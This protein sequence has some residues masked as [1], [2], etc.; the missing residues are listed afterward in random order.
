MASGVQFQDVGSNQLLHVTANA[1]GKVRE[2]IEDEGNADL[3]LRVYVTGGGCSGFQYGFTFDEKVADD[4]SIVQV[5]GVGVVV[6]ALSY[7]FLSGA[8]VDYEQGLA[9]SRFV[10][11]NPNAASTCGCGASFSI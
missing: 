5:D 7:P 8:T 3:K 9:G 11:T 1:V 4:D 2:L 10:V 6:D